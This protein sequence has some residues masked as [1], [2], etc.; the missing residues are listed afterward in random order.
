[1]FVT[2]VDATE[3]P[4]RLTLPETRPIFGVWPVD[5]ST[6]IIRTDNQAPGR[7]DILLVRMGVDTTVTPLVAGP[8][9]EV[10]PSL[11]PNGRWLAYTSDESGVDEVYVRP[12][13]RATGGVFKI[14]RAGGN[15]PRWSGTGSE[16]FFRDGSGTMV[17]VRVETAST[18]RVLSQQELFSALRFKSSTFGGQ[19]DV[20]R[21][22]Q[23]FLMIDQ[24]PPTTGSE[25]IAVLNWFTEL[26]AVV[27]Q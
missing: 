25:M 9:Q 4:R 7:G 24:V 14:S 26:R 11:S 2:S 16:L 18:F 17:S 15:E 23:R 19:Y 5:D 10:T 21:D 20:T 22:G 1:M 13:P 6:L 12:F 27:P 8:A 3:P